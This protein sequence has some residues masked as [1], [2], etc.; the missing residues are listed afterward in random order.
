MAIQLTKELLTRD[1]EELAACFCTI[2]QPKDGSKQKPKKNSS[3]QIRKFYDDFVLLK[4]KADRVDE[5]MFKKNILPLIYFSKAKI[6][7]SVARNLMTEGL[8]DKIIEWIEKIDSKE[9]FENFVKLFEA[10]I[11][12]ATYNDSLK[13]NQKT[14]RDN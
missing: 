9:D 3:S 10:M 14:G 5:E 12:Y 11:C 13:S 4:A 6:T 1:A 2:E 7:Y 8:K